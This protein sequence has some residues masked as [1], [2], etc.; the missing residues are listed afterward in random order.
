MLDV[1]SVG[2]SGS[3]EAFPQYRIAQETARLYPQRDL[4]AGEAFFATAA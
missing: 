4:V 2:I 1:R 3:W